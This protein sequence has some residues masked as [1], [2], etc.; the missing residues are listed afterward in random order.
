MGQKSLSTRRVS[1]QST[2]SQQAVVINTGTGNISVAGSKVTANTSISLD[3]VT[4]GSS[5]S[6]T[7]VSSG[8]TITSYT[9]TDASYVN[10]DD[11][12]VNTAGGYL[13]INGTGFSNSN[14]SVYFNNA[15]VS[16]TYVSSTEVR[17]VIPAVAAGTYSLMVFNGNVVLLL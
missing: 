15:L 5:S 8:P 14:L 16:N 1:A 17:A 13:K 12:A 9:V 11:T 2:V 7:T 3:V 10:L 4:S 6:V